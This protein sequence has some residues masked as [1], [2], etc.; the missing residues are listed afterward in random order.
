[1]LTCALCTQVHNCAS[2]E[3]GEAE[4]EGRGRGREHT[5]RGTHEDLDSAF[6]DP[7]SKYP[8]IPKCGLSL[9]GTECV[10]LTAH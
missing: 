9:G 2:T 3:M 8:N 4:G 5:C 1:M 10:L 7:S 6:P